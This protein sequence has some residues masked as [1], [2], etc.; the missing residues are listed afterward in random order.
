MGIYEEEKAEEVEEEVWGVQENILVA[1]ETVIEAEIE[2]VL[3][4]GEEQGYAV[5]LGKALTVKQKRKYLD[6]EI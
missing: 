4:V 1:K 3:D 2:E 6:F 5:L